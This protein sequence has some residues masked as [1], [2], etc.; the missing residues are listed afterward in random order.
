VKDELKKKV[1]SINGINVIAEKV[2]LD[3]PQAIKDLAFQLKGEVDNLFLVLGAEIDG[4]PSLSIMIADQLVKERGLNAGQ[5]VREAAKEMKG[6]G[7][8][9]PFYATAGGKDVSGI[10]AAIAKA[11][12]F[13]N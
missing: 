7:G 13:V 2:A 8:G 3:S 6:G 11:K 4:K 9:Q 12:S 1:S 10:E 5:I